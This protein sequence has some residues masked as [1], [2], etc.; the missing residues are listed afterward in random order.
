MV[1]NDW[2]EPCDLYIFSFSKKENTYYENMLKNIPK[3]PI[4]MNGDFY[5]T[6][7]LYY[8]VNGFSNTEQNKDKL[9]EDFQLR[10]IK[11][12]GLIIGRE[13]QMKFQKNEKLDI[14]T[15]FHDFFPKN[16][17]LYNPCVFKI[18]PWMTRNFKNKNIGWF[19]KMNQF[20][21]DYV[22][23]NYEIDTVAEFG[24]YMGYSSRYILSIKPTVK[25]YGFD[26]FRPLLFTKYSSNVITPIDTEF[27]FKYL[28]F[29]TFHR[30]IEKYKN[31]TTIVGDIY[32]NYELLKM[33][34]IEIQFVYIDFEKKTEPLYHFVKN[35]LDDYPNAIIIGDDYTFISVQ[36]AVEKM[37][38]LNLNV[39]CL[40]TCYI[41]AKKPLNKNIEVLK[42]KYEEYLK[43]I[44]EEDINKIKEF[45][46]IYQLLYV[47]KMIKEKED[48]NRLIHIIK[49]FNINLNKTY[50][51]LGICNIYNFLGRMYY[52]DEKYYL[53][54]YKELIKIERD[55][56]IKDVYNLTSKDYMKMDMRSSLL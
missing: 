35:I 37:K 34:K 46:L 25:Y 21:I 36:K 40:K 39:I 28:R 3:Y 23:K 47:K 26:I 30:N 27:Y 16:S 24:I 54:L 32:K 42:K 45:P 9:I 53:K 52:N 18:Q 49:L 13:S 55:K 22:F 56:D 50:N 19:N 4:Y 20:A 44:N 31:V 17:I 2:H 48:I 29:E 33:Y 51:I 1:W 38:K 6:P 43:Y 5:I 10:I 14:K 15:G 12:L 8:F 41:V 7:I 11:Q